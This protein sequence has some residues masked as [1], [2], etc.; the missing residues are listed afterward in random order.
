MNQQVLIP[1]KRPHGC[2][3]GQGVVQGVNGN[4]IGNPPYDPEPNRK[5]VARLAETLS[6]LMIADVLGIHEATLYRHHRTD[7]AKAKAI[8][9]E[10]MGKSVIAKADQGDLDAMKFYLTRHGGWGETNR[11]EHTGAGGGPITHVDVAR[12]TEAFRG[13]TEDER[14]IAERVLSLVAAG[15]PAGGPDS[16]SGGAADSQAGQP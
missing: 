8:R 3:R 12:L 5:L 1:E 15:G 14:A 11:T 7:I 10:K 9:V 6:N 4:P 16:G 2:P 13:M